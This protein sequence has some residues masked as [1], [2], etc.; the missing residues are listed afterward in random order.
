MI[1]ARVSSAIRIL[2]YIIIVLFSVTNYKS[3]YSFESNTPG[4]S[5]SSLNTGT[6]NSINAV[7]KYSFP[8]DSMADRGIYFKKPTSIR[9]GPK[10]DVFIVDSGQS[11]VIVFSKDGE[12]LQRIGNLGKGPGELSAPELIN[13]DEKGF[14][15]IYEWGNARIQIYDDRG[16]FLKGFKVFKYIEA[17]T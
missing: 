11:Q 16:K 3:V 6:N 13:F 7:F 1:R 12:C 17:L 2:S 8:D 5:A 14:M 4:F 10:G 15:Y 9:M